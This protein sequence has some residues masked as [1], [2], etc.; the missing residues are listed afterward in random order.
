MYD[1]GNRCEEFLLGTTFTR[2][3][4]HSPGSAEASAASVTAYAF[5]HGSLTGLTAYVI[6]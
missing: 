3:G 4:P 6:Q 5:A 1:A 2:N